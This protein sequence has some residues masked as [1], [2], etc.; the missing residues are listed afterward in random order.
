MEN[1]HTRAKRKINLKQNLE[2]TS[3][4]LINALTTNH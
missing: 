4:F 2:A 3:K 1:K